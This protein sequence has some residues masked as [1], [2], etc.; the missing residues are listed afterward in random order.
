MLVL[1]RPGELLPPDV[2]GSGLGEEEEEGAFSRIS[3][4]GGEIPWGDGG[5]S[6]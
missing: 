6:L 5:T 4:G 1:E 2:L 3:A